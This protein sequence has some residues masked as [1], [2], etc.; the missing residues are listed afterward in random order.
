M[1][2]VA[3]LLS[4]G[5]LVLHGNCTMPPTIAVF[6]ET[7]VKS[8]EDEELSLHRHRSLQLVDLRCTKS[9]L[10]F[11]FTCFPYWSHPNKWFPTLYARKHFFRPASPELQ[12]PGETKCRRNKA[13][14]L[15]HGCSSLSLLRPP[16]PLSLSPSL[17][18]FLPHRRDM[19]KASAVSLREEKF[20]LR[21]AGRH[22]SKHGMGMGRVAARRRRRRPRGRTD[23]KANGI[24]RRFIL[25]LSYFQSLQLLVSLSSPYLCLSYP[26]PKLDFKVE[27]DEASPTRIMLYKGP[28]IRDKM[29]D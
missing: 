1:T 6:W 27:D 19:P 28:A 13:T 26:G 17:S 22:I 20:S 2:R 29:R 23:A 8:V 10:P 12:I 25:C 7:A 24:W 9:Q 14:K 5:A 16:P 3:G 18:L 21:P 4:D 11:L 15:Q